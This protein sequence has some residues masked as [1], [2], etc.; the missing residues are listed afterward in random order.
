LCTETYFLFARQDS[1]FQRFVL[2]ASTKLLVD[3]ALT[4]RQDVLRATKDQDLDVGILGTKNTRIEGKLH[5]DIVNAGVIG[6]ARRME[7]LRSL[8]LGPRVDKVRKVIVRVVLQRLNL[9]EEDT[10]T[11]LD[12]RR[13]VELDRDF[14]NGIQKLTRRLID[15]TREIKVIAIRSAFRAHDKDVLLNRVI[16]LETD[17]GTDARRVFRSTRRRIVS[18]RRNDLELVNELRES[19]VREKITLRILKVDLVGL[20][21]ACKIRVAERAQCKRTHRKLL[22]KLLIRKTIGSDANLAARR[23]DNAVVAARKVNVVRDAVEAQGTDGQGQVAVTRV[24]K[25]QRNLKL[26]APLRKTL[27]G[28][29]RV[30]L[31]N[32]IVDFLAGLCRQD[33][34]DVQECVRVRVND[35]AT[36]RKRDFTQ[37]TVADG[38]LPVRGLL[39]RH[40]LA[41]L[42]GNNTGQVDLGL[43]LPGKVTLTRKR[44]LGLA[45]KTRLGRCRIK[46]NRLKRE[47]GVAVVD[48]TPKVSLS[49][50][51]LVVRQEHIRMALVANLSL[52]GIVRGTTHLFVLQGIVRRNSTRSHFNQ[53]F[54]TS[55]GCT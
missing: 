43:R 22:L 15:R 20:E 37:E 49:F 8:G 2:E 28:L 31:T 44:K 19:I 48:K 54:E 1:I 18:L 55:F 39:A 40:N 14:T 26:A 6:P 23:I 35:R 30:L 12:T 32:E 17:V 11:S 25:R 51:G 7:A 47:R 42:D 29:D 52:N 36:N 24:R 10:R 53:S 41:I 9:T 33:V 45:T 4:V 46:I 27:L 34:P 3:H 38:V 21:R 13:V 50:C 5:V 16:K